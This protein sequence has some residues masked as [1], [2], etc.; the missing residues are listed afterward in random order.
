MKTTHPTTTT[1]AALKT[2]ATGAAFQEMFELLG[3]P[4]DSPI[5]SRTAFFRDIGND[6]L[7]VRLNDGK[8]ENV[9]LEKDHVGSAHRL[10]PSY[11]G[12]CGFLWTGV[13]TDQGHD[14]M[15]S[16]HVARPDS[17][18][19]LAAWI[20]ASKDLL[21]DPKLDWSPWTPTDSFEPKF[22]AKIFPLIVEGWG[23]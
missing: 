10:F 4:S 18:P 1:A 20:A 14:D 22:L 21:A 13:S 17:R 9:I 23:K 15:A 2:A 6:V 11:G 8:L 19:A 16:G 12:D 3:S 7:V 5:E